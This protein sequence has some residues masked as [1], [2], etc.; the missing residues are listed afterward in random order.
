MSKIGCLGRGGGTPLI[1]PLTPKDLPQHK[2]IYLVNPPP[3]I[4]YIFFLRLGRVRHRYYRGWKGRDLV[5]NYLS[6]DGLS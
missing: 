3:Q 4:Q 6:I 5:N 1:I 2:L